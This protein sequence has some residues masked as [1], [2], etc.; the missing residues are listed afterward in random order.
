MLRGV[1]GVEECSGHIL[2]V[3]FLVKLAFGSTMSTRAT[4][5]F[6]RRAYKRKN[7]KKAHIAKLRRAE[8]HIGTETE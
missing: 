4:L 1:A 2:E 8:Q 5:K 6:T 3:V 7:P